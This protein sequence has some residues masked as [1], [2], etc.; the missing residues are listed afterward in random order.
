MACSGCG[1]KAITTVQHTTPITTT[2]STHQQDDIQRIYELRMAQ[3]KPVVATKIFPNV[4]RQ[5]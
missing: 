5:R 1:A 2:I 3:Q 4:P